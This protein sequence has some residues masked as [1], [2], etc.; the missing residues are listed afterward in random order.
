MNGKIQV[1]LWVNDFFFDLGHEHL[2]FLHLPAKNLA[3]E[4]WRIRLDSLNLLHR[5]KLTYVFE[6]GVLGPRADRNLSYPRQ[7]SSEFQ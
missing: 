1:N 6:F 7:I 3:E 2:D 4:S 5:L